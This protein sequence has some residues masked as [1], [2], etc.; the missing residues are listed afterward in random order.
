MNLGGTWFILSHSP[1]CKA[2]LP[3]VDRPPRMKPCLTDLPYR[4]TLGPSPVKFIISFLAILKHS[5]QVRCFWHRSQPKLKTRAGTRSLPR[6]S[7]SP[8]CQP[9]HHRLCCD[10]RTFRAV[11]GLQERVTVTESQ[12]SK[13]RGSTDLLYSANLIAFL[14]CLWMVGQSTQN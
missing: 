8:C 11:K 7:Q 12:Y 2:H 6:W 9:L 5:Y 10:T 14:G 1:P 4:W 13:M 3:R